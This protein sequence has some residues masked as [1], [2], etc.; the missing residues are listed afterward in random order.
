MPFDT[1]VS[2]VHAEEV[3]KASIVLT[4]IDTLRQ[5]NFTV[6]VNS[7]GNNI[8]RQYQ[9]VNGWLCAEK[10]LQS[11]IQGSELL[12]YYWYRVI[13]VDQL[14]GGYTI[15][16]KASACSKTTIAVDSKLRD[17][18]FV[19]NEYNTLTSETSCRIQ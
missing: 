15:N 4:T 13:Y 14:R 3:L 16:T 8:L 2:V 5:G 17:V 12:Q 18:V 1:P 10:P 11:T 19:K 9:D 7:S 6:L